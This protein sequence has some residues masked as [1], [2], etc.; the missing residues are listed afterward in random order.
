MSLAEDLRR[1]FESSAPRDLSSRPA[2]RL[3]SEPPRAGIV[4]HLRDARKPAVDAPVGDVAHESFNLLDR[5]SKSV[6]FV[7]ARYKQLE[8]HVRQLD[9]WSKAQ[10]QAAEVASTRWQEAAA[11]S[12]RKMGEAQQALAAMN[13]R[14]ETAERDLKRDRDTLQVLQNRIVS[15]FGFGSEAHDALASVELD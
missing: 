8:E 6:V 10:I 5:A 9:A 11:E 13:R 14:A 2:G 4:K 7:L 12:E 1:P 3:S 15:A